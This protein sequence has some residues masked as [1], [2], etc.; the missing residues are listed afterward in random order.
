MNN[1]ITF[2]SFDGVRRVK[3]LREETRVP[4]ESNIYD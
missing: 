2:I 3:I 1:S 4:G